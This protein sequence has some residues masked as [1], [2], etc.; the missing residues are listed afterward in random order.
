MDSV[1][2]LV[3]GI[4]QL[5]DESVFTEKAARGFAVHTRIVTAAPGGEAARRAA[6]WD[7]LEAAAGEIR[8]R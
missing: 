2:V 7:D 5:V 3:A 6:R 1:A 4:N 8:L